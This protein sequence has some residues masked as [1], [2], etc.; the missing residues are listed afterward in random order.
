MKKTLRMFA[1]LL[2][3]AVSFSTVCAEQKKL[4]KKVVK[5]KSTK[6]KYSTG[7]LDLDL[8]KLPSNYYGHSIVAIYDALDDI[9]ET[10]AKGDFETT[11]KYQARLVALKKQPLIGKLSKQD[12]FAL[13]LPTGFEYNA[14]TS[15][16]TVS[17]ATRKLIEY[18]KIM[19]YVTFIQEISNKNKSYVGIVDP[20]FRTIV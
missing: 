13:S 10:P 19:D 3:I 8:Q 1:I 20:I 7:A 11:E 4:P 5:T 15:L 18:Y 9:N 16:L 12:I 2:L 17:V 14:D 6:T